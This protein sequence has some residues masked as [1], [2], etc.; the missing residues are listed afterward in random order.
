VLVLGLGLRVS[1]APIRAE[2]HFE[3]NATDLDGEFVV[4]CISSEMLRRVRV[5]APD[6]EC[7]LDVSGVLPL[8]SRW[9]VGDD[10]TLP[11][12]LSRYP[13]GAYAI[14]AWTDE[15]GRRTIRAP[16]SHELADAATIAV[17]DQTVIDPGS[18]VGW[19][20]VRDATTYEVHVEQGDRELSWR[21]GAETRSVAI[22]RATFLRGTVCHLDVGARLPNGNTTWVESTFYIAPERHES[23][24]PGE[25]I[26]AGTT[27][28]FC[29]EP[30]YH[31]VLENA[32]GARLERTVLGLA[33]FRLGILTRVVEDR[34]FDDGQLVE[35]VRYHLAQRVGTGEVLCFGERHTDAGGLEIAAVRDP[36]WWVFVPGTDA[37]PPPGPHRWTG[38]RSEVLGVLPVFTIAGGTYRDVLLVAERAAEGAEPPILAY[39]G[40][41]LGL[42][43]RAGLE[44]TTVGFIV[45][46]DDDDD[47]GD[48][49]DGD[50]D[51]D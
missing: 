35:V 20:A 31:Q 4:T 39:Y 26:A 15:G 48:D 32:T 14:D 47:D 1:G 2:V 6:G 9:T 33:E 7:L 51:D 50:T 17:P 25:F 38:C 30:G 34:R 29:L 23:A 36:D 21:G 45:D 42:L 46:D 43:R 18:E 3:V 24:P 13:E 40:L 41:G 8:R 44:Q 5:S 37:A 10:T 19:F 12:L 28:Y 22:P 16:L 11:D 49:D 27:G